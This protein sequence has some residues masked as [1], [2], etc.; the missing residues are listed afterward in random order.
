VKKFRHAFGSTNVNT[1]AWVEIIASL[2]TPASYVEVFNSSGAILKLSTG[3]AAAEDDSEIAYYILPNGSAIMLPME[4]GN[5]Q[6]ISARAIDA[7]A[8]V[9]SLVLNFF[10]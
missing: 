7:N 3:A 1:T 2:D 6:R 10:D 8:T 9:G 5:G 4:F